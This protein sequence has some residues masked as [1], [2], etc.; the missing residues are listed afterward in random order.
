VAQEVV[1]EAVRRDDA[2][3]PGCFALHQHCHLAHPQHLLP[4][5][6]AVQLLYHVLHVVHHLLQLHQRQSAAEGVGFNDALQQ[7]G[8]LVGSD[9][10]ML[11][12]NQQAPMSAVDFKSQ[13]LVAVG[14]QAHVQFLLEGLSSAHDGYLVALPLF[15]VERLLA[16]EEVLEQQLLVSHHCFELVLEAIDDAGAVAG[17]R[18]GGG[19]GL[20]LE[21]DAAGL[22]LQDGRSVDLVEGG[23]Q[24]ALR[25]QLDLLQLVLEVRV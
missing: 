21:R 17:R 7:E 18:K 22:E 10:L 9:G 24:D 16:A 3:A 20:A 15:E 25:H 2:V 11:Q 8:V 23:E 19:L 13:L 4:A 12:L 5:T 1:V 14:Q 6:T